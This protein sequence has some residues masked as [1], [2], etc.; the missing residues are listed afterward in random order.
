M[1]DT[2]KISNFTIKEKKKGF[3]GNEKE[4]LTTGLKLSRSLHICSDMNTD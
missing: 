3:N 1:P 4:K 2:F